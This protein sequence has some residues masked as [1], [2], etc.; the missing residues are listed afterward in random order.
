MFLIFKVSRFS[1]VEVYKFLL[2]LFVVRVRLVLSGLLSM[3][4]NSFSGRLGFWLLKFFRNWLMERS[5]V[6]VLVSR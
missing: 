1:V 4:R 2:I 5:K 3:V 6:G